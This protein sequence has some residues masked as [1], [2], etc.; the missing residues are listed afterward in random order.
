MNQVLSDRLRT[1]EVLDSQS[2][3]C[4]QV[5]GL[6]WSCPDGIAYRTLDEA[7]AAETLEIVE[8]SEV[9][10]VPLLKVLNRGDEPVLLMAGEQLV[11]A[12]QNR[13]LNASILAA[14]R[15]EVT[16]P[17]SCVEAGRWHYSSRKFGSPGTMSHGKLR[18][19]LSRRVH[20]SAARGAGAVSKQGE[21]WREV[22][23]KLACLGSVSPSA[24]LQQT[25]QDFQARL[26][27]LL[28]GLRV[29]PE[30]TG[31][32]FAIAGRIAGMD[33]F[34]KA[35]TLTK[36]W[37]KLARAF[38]LD[39]LEGKDEATPQVTCEGVRRWL[40]LVADA[41]THIS[42]SPGLGH[43]LRLRDEQTVGCCLVVEDLPVHTELFTL[44][45][46]AA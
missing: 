9:G 35:T 16:I 6:R 25:Y 20:E 32:A 13:V 8:T 45:A 17:V 44:D 3:G 11:G 33:L 46:S 40:D 38:A 43:D 15:G 22:G 37:P 14:E 18:S 4:L 7:L 5:F 29:S 12:K 36:L 31:C 1:V 23:R 24:A 30:C 27:S 19:L 10:S 26:D 41:P 42:K 28:G 39:A 21:V 34:D 2:V